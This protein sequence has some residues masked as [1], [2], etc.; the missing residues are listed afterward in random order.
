MLIPAR[1]E[2]ATIEACLRSVLAQTYSRLEVLVVD[3]ASEDSTRS[4]VERAMSSDA[5][6]NLL[7]N[8]AQGIPQAL[9]IGLSAAGGVWI[10]RIDAH[11]SVPSNYIAGVVAHLRSGL[12]DG[13][14][15]RKDGVGETPAGRAIA[16]VLGSPLG[17]GGSVYHHGT[18]P[19]TVDHIPF[20]AYAV[21]LLR[22]LGGWNED[23]FA[24]EDYELDLR[25]RSRGGRLLFDP[26]LRIDWRCRQSL[27]GLW[28]QYRRYG[29]GKA[30]V[31]KLHPA[32]LSPRHLAP[33]GYVLALTVAALRRGPGSTA[34]TIIPYLAFVV[35]ATVAV[36]RD[37]AHPGERAWLPLVWPTMHLAYGI[38]FWEGLAFPGASRLPKAALTEWVRS[39]IS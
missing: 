20:G 7:D 34:L 32:S 8:P 39:K 14:G 26:E 4:I 29:R 16:A 9:N 24:N 30:L 23:L 5:R 25:I 36:S 13:V 12:W 10:V 15:G 37:L 28:R 11:S 17:V 19:Q 27:P 33:P 31:A 2:E 22:A 1:N 21:E 38:G 3:G 6:V 35:F 18:K